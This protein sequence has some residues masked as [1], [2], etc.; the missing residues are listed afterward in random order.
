[1]IYLSPASWDENGL[2]KEKGRNTKVSQEMTASK[3]ARDGALL[4]HGVLGNMRNDW[5]YQRTT[6]ITKQNTPHSYCIAE[7]CWLW[8]CGG[9]I[10]S[11]YRAHALFRCSLDIQKAMLNGRGD[12][13][14]IINSLMVV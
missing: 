3:Q 12:H 1:M 9:E 4:S 13:V 8:H 11:L 10:R 14:F 6:T 2:S 5:F 7:N